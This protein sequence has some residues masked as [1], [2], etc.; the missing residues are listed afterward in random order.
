MVSDIS[1]RGNHG[2]LV[3]FS[4]I[5]AGAGDFNSSEGWLAE[6]GLSFLDGAENQLNY[7]ETPLPLNSLYD[8]E[9]K[10]NKS[11]TIELVANWAGSVGWSP[12]I[13]SNFGCQFSVADAFFFGLNNSSQALHL[14]VPGAHSKT[15]YSSGNP[16]LALNREEHHI[17]IVFDQFSSR[18]DLFI[19]GVL[20]GN[21]TFSD[22]N[23][24]K[25][26]LFRIGNV[27]WNGSEQWG[28]N[29]YSVAISDK[30]LSPDEFVLSRIGQ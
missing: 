2:M 25:R 6:G 7:I 18:A 8:S 3:G 20:A 4:D 22:I 5:S 24:N 19:D 15:F 9:L 13:G 16:W 1:G 28:G 21:T 12:V 29:I 10:Q 11:F 26:S 30:S 27:G 23:L 17:A 14:R